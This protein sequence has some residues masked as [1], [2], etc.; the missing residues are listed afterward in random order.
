[1][2]RSIR[3][4]ICAGI[5]ISIGGAVYLACGDRKYIGAVLFTV[6]L[7]SICFRGYALFTGRVGFIVENHKKA[8]VSELLL[9]LLGNA[10]GTVVCGLL[11]R[12]AITATGDAAQAVCEAK[13][14]QA[15]PST[16]IRA[17]FCGVLMY[18]A[19]SVYREN[20][21][22]VGILFCIPVFIIAGFEHS[23]ADM[24]YFAASG[25][26]SARAC[27]FIWI[28]ILGNSVGAMILPAL[29]FESKKKKPKKGG[30]Q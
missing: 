7:L 22:V 11:I 15:I 17:I 8:D 29:S 28:V 4:G 10:I 25:I 19:V 9:C 13:L 18:I 30:K 1:M 27:G 5:M 24:F 21:S 26:V 14:T 12:Y 20:K 23:I 2:L 3:S 6:A 16:F